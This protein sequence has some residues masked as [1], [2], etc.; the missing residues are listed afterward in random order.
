[1]LRDMINGFFMALADSVPGVSGGTVAFIMGFYDDFIGSIH[2]LVY[3][4]RE[5]KR[6]GAVYLLR[7]GA[8]WALGMMLAVVILT[9][10]FERH[11]YIVSSVFTGF[12]AASVPLVVHDERKAFSRHIPGG[13]VSFIAGLLLVTV[14]SYLNGRTASQAMDL[15][16][17]SP[18]LAVRLFFIGMIAISAM[19][20]PGISGSTLLL[21]FG[22]YMP[23]MNAVRS[24]LSFDFQCVPLLIFFVSGIAFG[25]VSIVKLI[26]NALD[27]FRSETLYAVIGM[28]TGS[29]YA[30]FMGPASLSPPLPPL[31]LSSFC[32]PGA[33]AGAML[34]LILE[35]VRKKTER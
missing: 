5:E 7:L 21:V 24:V 10:L 6:K 2:S 29:L 35:L 23:V 17:F 16:S 31:S 30:I 19:F 13:I 26:K 11:I 33:V 1:M 14:V 4:K 22:A 12:I 18:F 8:G 25:A 28:M 34:V 20:L 32:W 27:K 3:G 15:S 9:S